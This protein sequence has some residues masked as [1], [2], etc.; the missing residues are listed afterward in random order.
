MKY[1]DHIYVIG[2]EGGKQKV[3]I[4]HNPKGRLSGLQ[5]ASP[6][7]LVGQYCALCETGDVRQIEVEAHKHLANSH[8]HGEWFQVDKDTAIRVIREAAETTGLTLIERPQSYFDNRLRPLTNVFF[9]HTYT[10]IPESTLVEDLDLLVAQYLN[11]DIG[12]TKVVKEL[13]KALLTHELILAP[14][15]SEAALNMRV[16]RTTV[17]SMLKRLEIN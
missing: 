12:Y 3:G 10:H 11:Q 7:K 4:S 6:E 13:Q 2:V 15:V 9:D 8:S 17:Y 5:T 1:P 14:T 16:D